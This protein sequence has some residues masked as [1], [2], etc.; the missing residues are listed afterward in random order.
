MRFSR[1]SVPIAGARRHIRAALHHIDGAAPALPAGK[2]TRRRGP[3]QRE[4]TRH[5]R[6]SA[7]RRDRPQIVDRR[8]RC[9]SRPSAA[10]RPRKPHPPLLRRG[11]R[12]RS[13]PA[14]P[15]RPTSWAWWSTAS[16][17]TA[18]CAAAPNC[19][20]SAA[21][22]AARRR[23]P[24]ASRSPGRATASAAPCSSARCSAPATAASRRCT[25][26]CLADNRRMQQLARKFEADLKFDFGSVVG[27]VDAARLDAAIDHARMCGRRA[28]RAS[29]HARC[30]GAVA[31]G[32]VSFRRPL[33]SSP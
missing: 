19:A 26:H 9:L 5:A 28:W 31:A 17:S 27:E 6:A 18:C 24:S 30:A 32:G 22:S 15:P 12:R 23:P 1:T 3:C 14:M 11:L 16:S 25:M 8:G 7:R 33:R 10:P 21:C 4:E 13:S 2:E 29:R 20:I